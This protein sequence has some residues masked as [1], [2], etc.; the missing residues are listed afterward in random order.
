MLAILTYS[1]KYGLVR[2]ATGVPLPA[3]AAAAALCVG[4]GVVLAVVAAIY[5]ARVAA[6]MI[7]AAALSSHV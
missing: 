5:P 7:P 4:A 1:Y 2:V 3:L 6:K